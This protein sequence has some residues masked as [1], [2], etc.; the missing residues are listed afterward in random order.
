LP[1]D[2]QVDVFMIRDRCSSLSSWRNPDGRVACTSETPGGC[3]NRLALKSLTHKELRRQPLA[4]R[5]V[6]R[7][8]S[9]FPQNLQISMKMVLTTHLCSVKEGM[10]LTLDIN[11][12]TLT[13]QSATPTNG[14]CRHG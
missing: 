2:P 14:R 11:C 6:S 4:I 7:G 8:K 1:A 3:R 13:P 12:P 5:R 9:R 10:T